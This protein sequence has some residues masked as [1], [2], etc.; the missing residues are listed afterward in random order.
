VTAEAAAA[1]VGSDARHRAAAELVG[2][3]A[4][5]RH[6]AA[7]E[8]AVSAQPEEAAAEVVAPDVAEGPQQAA[9]PDVGVA[10]RREGAVA[11]DAGVQPP[12]EVVELPSAAAWVFHPGQ[13]RA[14]PAPT[15]RV[16]SGRAMP[17]LRTASP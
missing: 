14:P 4:R 10:P 1:E 7:A 3:D 16:R 9:E 8:P 5:A 6:W 17:S 12:A 11:R 13:R 15:P 2:S